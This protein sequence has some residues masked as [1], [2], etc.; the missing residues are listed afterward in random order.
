MRAFV[1]AG[2]ILAL[3]ACSPAA[4]PAG[5]ET[6]PA[7]QTAAR[8]GSVDL[9]QPIR[10]SGTE[11]FWF[12][13]IADGVFTWRDDSDFVGDIT[14]PRTAAASPVVTGDTAVYS[15]T[16]SDG[17]AMRLTLT[18]TACPDIG[19]ETRAL[20]ASLERDGVTRSACADARTAY[21]PELPAA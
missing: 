19:E 14:T 3:A 4:E 16:L 13:D 6:V 2:L 17:T 10:A 18:A 8:L 9:T 20:T 11:P 7:A 5:A 15:V 12:I 1:P 21:P